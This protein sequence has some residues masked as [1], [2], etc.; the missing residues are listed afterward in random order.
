MLIRQ[1]N[2]ERGQV[3]LLGLVIVIILGLVVLFLF[4]LQLAV[5]AKMKVETAEQSAALAAAEWQ[6]NSLN[7]IGE[8]N[9]IK[10][11]DA[12]LENYEPADVEDN[13]QNRQ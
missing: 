7:L 1:T 8:L 12:M 2:K 9:L 6:R 13:G 4:D 10:A 11:C 3:M 5:R